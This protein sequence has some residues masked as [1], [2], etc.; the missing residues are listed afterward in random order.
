MGFLSNTGIRVRLTLVVVL[1]VLP[2]FGLL[3]FHAAEDRNRKLA[4]LEEDAARVAALSAA[5]LSQVVSGTRHFLFAL[6]YEEPVRT[7]DGAAASSLFAE[8]LAFSPNLLNMGFLEPRSNV[9]VNALTAPDTLKANERPWFRRLQQRRT[10]TVGEYQISQTTGRPTVV[11]SYP[12]PGQAAGQPV[13]AVYALLNLDALQACIT[14]QHRIPDGVIAVLDRNGVEL[15]RTPH[16]QKWIGTRLS[17]WGE[18]KAWLAKG[19]GK[20]GFVTAGVDD[21][22][23]LYFAAPVPGSDDGLFVAV[24]VARETLLETVRTDFLRNLFWLLAFTLA[25]LACAWC[26]ANASLIR[27]VKKL[28]AAS[29]R[30]AEGQ[31]ETSILPPGEAQELQQLG[32]AFEEMAAALRKHQ[33]SLEEQVHSRTRQLVHTNGRLQAEIDERKLVEAASKKLLAELKRSNRELE[34]FAYVASHDLQE[35]LRLVSAYTQLLLQRYKDRLDADADPI[36][37][38][39]TEGVGRM[40]QLIRDLLAYSRVGAKARPF[41]ET[42]LEE[43]LAAVCQN[44]AMTIEENGASVTHDPLPSILC[45]PLLLSQLFQNLI[46]NGIKFHGE[47]PPAIHVGAR[48]TDDGEGWLFAVSDNG[49]GIEQEYFERIF[50][51]FQRLHTRAKYSGTGIGL[52]ICKRIVEHHGGEIWVESTPGK[53]CIFFFTIPLKPEIVAS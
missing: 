29:R 23:R 43:V 20:E 16:P 44:L 47:E 39:I 41:T 52:A 38:F 48:K 12:L 21:V 2:M 15:A 9:A 35:P 14:R 17:N 40:Q 8:L 45:D 25:A 49:I 4:A 26:F 46:A 3:L 10:F 34:Q 5:S 53:G 31:W 6:A 18:F 42:N 13:A 33:D 1:A 30:L 19:K 24:G 28:T 27:P 7:N 11:L 22:A 36:V 32:R 51:I 50:V 37:R